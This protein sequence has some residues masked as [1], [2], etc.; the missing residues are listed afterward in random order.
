MKAFLIFFMA[1]VSCHAKSQSPNPPPPDNTIPAEPC[2]GAMDDLGGASG[3]LGLINYERSKRGL[4][5]LA[6][7]PALMC[8]AR[9]H[10]IDVAKTGLCTHIGS[11]LSQFWQRAKKC[12]GVASGEVIACGQVDA[13]SVVEAWSKDAAHAQIIYDP[14]QRFVGGYMKDNYWVVIFRK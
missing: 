13:I 2:D 7:D 8:A 6:N 11:D 12:G 3:V 5:G 10:A 4:F 9:I 1:L 14:K